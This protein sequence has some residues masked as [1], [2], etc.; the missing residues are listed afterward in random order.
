MPLSKGPIPGM[1]H[2]Q[3]L[4][5]IQTMVDH[6]QKWHDSSSSQNVGSSNNIDGLAIIIAREEDIEL[7]KVLSCQ[8]PPKE[9]NLGSFSLPC[10]IGNFNFYA[11]A[12]LGASVNVTPKEYMNT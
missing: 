3:S 5:A 8:L 7:A 6:S 2:A 4:T 10:T 11:M 9:L 1:T 12:D